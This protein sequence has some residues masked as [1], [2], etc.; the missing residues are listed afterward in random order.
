MLRCVR[1]FSTLYDAL[2]A[3]H[4]AD[5]STTPVA[6]IAFGRALFV[7]ASAAHHRVLFVKVRHSES[8]RAEE[9][10]TQ[11]PRRLLLN[12]RGVSRAGNVA[13]SRID[14][15]LCSVDRIEAI[16]NLQSEVIPE[17]VGVHYTK[18]R[19]QA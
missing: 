19:T 15:R 12:L 13:R 11:L 8:P 14:T 1:A 18:T 2:E 9:V 16:L 6:R 5:K 17:V 4:H 3:A 7:P 10:K